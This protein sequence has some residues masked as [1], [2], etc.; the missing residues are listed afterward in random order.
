MITPM[1]AHWGIPCR[2]QFYCMYKGKGRCMYHSGGR[3]VISLRAIIISMWDIYKLECSFEPRFFCTMHIHIQWGSFSFSQMLLRQ[4]FM[5]SRR[6]T[7]LT[8]MYGS[9]ACM[10]HRWY[11]VL[12][13][14]CYTKTT[15]KNHTCYLF[16]FLTKRTALALHGSN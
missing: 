10:M 13:R 1:C 7:R 6:V 2:D 4:C 15:W 9:A 8:H 5:L 3:G 12:C 14:I 11:T 16:G